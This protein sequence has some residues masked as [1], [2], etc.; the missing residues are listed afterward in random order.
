[1]IFCNMGLFFPKNM[2]SLY[3]CASI[4]LDT[5]QTIK[6]ISKFWISFCINFN[7]CC[8]LFEKILW[9]WSMMQK[10]LWPQ[11]CQFVLFCLL[12]FVFLGLHLLYMEVPR[13]GVQSE[14]QLP[15]YTTATAT[16][17]PSLVCDLHRTKLR[18]TPDPQP[19]E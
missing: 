2:F 11:S 9:H 7:Y 14:L 5:K 15:A 16:Q 17:H 18:A 13:L 4:P 6:K 12:F 3:V 1:M 19:T 8:V 10:S